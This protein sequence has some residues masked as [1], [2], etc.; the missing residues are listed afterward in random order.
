[1][2]MGRTH[3][4]VAS[5]VGDLTVLVDGDAVCGVYF[6]GHLR[7]PASDELGARDDDG[8]VAV[9]RQLNEYFAGERTVFDLALAPQGNAFQLRV[10]ELLRAIPYGQTR[11]YGELARELGD[12]SLAQAVGAANARNPLSIIVPCHRVIAADGGLTGYAGGLERKR[13]LLELEAP[14][15]AEC[16][17]LF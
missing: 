17:R 1:M 5:P 15:P 10:W 12:G 14:E 11:S 7:G 16:G 13:F 8:I 3:T 9:R 4:V 2:T 6:D